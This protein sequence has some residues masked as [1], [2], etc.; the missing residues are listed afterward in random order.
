MENEGQSNRI[1][2]DSYFYLKVC[3]EHYKL[4][5]EYERKASSTLAEKTES[6]A[7]KLEAF[8]L[9]EEMAKCGATVVIFAAFFLEAWIYEYTVKKFS[10]SFFDNHVDRLAPASKWVIVTRCATGRNFP[11]D[12][13]AYQ[14]L[15][16]LYR[17]RNGLVHP[18]PSPKPQD[19]EKVLEKE[20]KERE[21]LIRNAHES[22]Q[23]CKEV[24]LELDKVENN[25]KASEWSIQFEALFFKEGV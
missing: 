4:L 10:M 6:F 21:Q 20:E 8:K 16:S 17:A 5:K 19:A 3:E 18:K 13:Q 2:L 24:I 15:K 12:S 23:T 1:K 7:S 9:Q 14:H 22:Y 11:T 25:G